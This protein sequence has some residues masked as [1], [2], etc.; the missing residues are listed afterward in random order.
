MSILSFFDEILPVKER[1]K[2]DEEHWIKRKL[3]VIIMD[4]RRI[5]FG[6]TN[7][8]YAYGYFCRRMMSFFVRG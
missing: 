4:D 3:Q 2:N 8:L 5:F 1:I 7:T 6:F